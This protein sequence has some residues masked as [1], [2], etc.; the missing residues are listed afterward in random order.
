MIRSISLICFSNSSL[1][2]EKHI[3]STEPRVYGTFV[4]PPTIHAPSFA[5]THFMI[6]QALVDL[7]YDSAIQ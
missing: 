1:V 3:P 5:E 4:A 2:Q 7:F 6:S